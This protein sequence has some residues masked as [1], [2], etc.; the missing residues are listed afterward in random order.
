MCPPFVTPRP[1]SLAAVAL[2]C[3]AHSVPSLANDGDG[4]ETVFE[5]NGRASWYGEDFEGKKT[6]SGERFDPAELTAAHRTLPLGSE[7][8][9]TDPETGRQ[10][11]V[12]INDRGPYKPGRIIDLS[13]KAADELGITEQGVAKVKV[14]ATGEQLDAAKRDDDGRE[15]R[16]EGDGR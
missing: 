11:E 7:V 12:E 6:A 8:T 3:F 2:L 1:L 16:A 14:E 5:Q 13:K 9:V 15:E 10:V 4:E